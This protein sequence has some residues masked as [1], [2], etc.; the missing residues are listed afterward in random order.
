MFICKVLLFVIALSVY[1]Y[2]MWCVYC[3]VL[4]RNPHGQIKLYTKGADTI[5][6]DRLDPS[7]EDLMYTTSEHLSVSLFKDLTLH[8][9]YN[10]CR[11]TMYLYCQINKAVKVIYHI[12]VR[13]IIIAAFCAETICC[14]R[15]FIDSKVWFVACSYSMQWHAEWY[16]LK[17]VCNIE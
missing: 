2:K 14:A 3:F 12:N 15:L 8:N 10:Y 5:I 7:S 13:L 17:D 6:F 9:K 11:C 4:V 16:I 1:V